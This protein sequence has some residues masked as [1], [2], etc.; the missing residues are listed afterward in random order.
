MNSEENDTD[1]LLPSSGIKE[2]RGAEK[3]YQSHIMNGNEIQDRKFTFKKK[4]EKKKDR[5]F[6]SNNC[7]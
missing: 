1:V 5:Y 2:N 7:I 4:G 3:E 6:L